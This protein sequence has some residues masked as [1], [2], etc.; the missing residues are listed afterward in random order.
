MKKNYFLLFFIILTFN[1]TYSQI[2]WDFNSATGLN[3]WSL[4]RLNVDSYTPQ[5]VI[6]LPNGQNNPRLGNTIAGIDADVYKFAIIKLKVASGGSDFIRINYGANFKAT[7]ITTGTSSIETYVINMTDPTWTGIINSIELAFRMNDGSAGGDGAVASGN[8]IELQEITFIENLYVGA[9]ELYVDLNAGNDNNDGSSTNPLLTIPHAID[10]A[11]SNNIANVYIKSGTYELTATQQISTDSPNPIVVSPEAN[12][13]VKFRTQSNIGFNFIND[14]NNIEF[15]GFEVDGKASNTE[16]WHYTLLS[17]YVWQPDLLTDEQRGG[18]IAFNVENASNIKITNNSIH[19][20]YQ[21]SVNIRNG[22]YVTVKGNVIYNIALTSLSGG[23]GIMRQQGAGSFPDADDPLKYRWDIDGNL[24]FNIHQR[25]YSWV[26]A[27]GYLNMTLDEGKPILIDETPNHDLGMKARIKDNIVAYFKIDG[28][29]IKPTNYLEVSN[30]SLY[31]TEPVGADGITDTTNG[32]SGS[33]TPFLEFKCFNNAVELDPLRQPYE[34]AESIGSTGS[35]YGNNHAAFGTIAPVGVATNLNTSL[36]EDAP[37]GYF[38]IKNGLP[39]NIGVNPVIIEE[40]ATRATQFNVEVA[41]NNWINNHLKNT[42]TLFDNIPGVDDGIANNETVFLDAGVYDLSDLEYSNGRKS[43][44]FSVNT[45][46]QTD[47]EVTNAVLNHGN[48]LDIYDG[49]YEIVTPEVYSEW[50]DDIKANHLRDTDN[51]GIGDTP[52]AVIRYGESVIRQNKILNDNSLH[53]IEIEA[54]YDYT[55]THAE[56]FDITLDGDI[57]IDFNYTPAGYEV[58]DLIIANNITTNNITD[59][60]DHITILGYTGSYTLEIVAGSPSVLRLTLTDL[61]Q[62]IIWKN[63]QWSNITG[64][65]PTDNALIDDDFNENVSIVCNDLTIKDNWIVTI[66]STNR[67]KVNGNLIN[68]G[69]IV[70]KSDAS[71]TGRFDSFSGSI[72]GPGKATVERFIPQG[73]RAFRF[74][75]PGVTTTNF[76]KNNWQ[77]DTHI[78]GSTTGAFGFDTT[79]TGNPSMFTYNNQVISGTGWTAIPSTNTTNLVAGLGYR[80]L[81]RGDRN[82]DIFSPSTPNM[83]AATTLKATGKITSGSITLNSSSIPAI[84]NTNNTT[85]ADFSLIGNPYISPINW[86]TITKSGLSNTY[87]AWD[88]NMGTSTQ[89]GRYVAY[90]G[91]T[92]DN[93]SSEVNEFIQTGQ[94][95]FVKNN[96]SGVAGSITFTENDKA[97]SVTNIYKST[98]TNISKI[99]VSLYDTQILNSGEIYPIDATTT[100]FNS[101]YSNFTDSFDA[102]KLESPGE[103]IAWFIDGTKL[104]INAF[105]EPTNTDVLPIKTLRLVANKTYSLK[106]K[107]EELNINLTAFL[108]DNYLNTSTI[109]PFDTDYFYDYLTNDDSNS[110]SENRFNIVFNST[111]DNKDFDLN[112]IRVYP[113]PSNS[114]FGFYL[115]NSTSDDITVTLFNSLGQSIKLNKEASFYKPE[116]ILNDGVYFIKIISGKKIKTI[117]WIVN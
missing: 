49:K 110:Y 5:S 58:F 101:S 40:L 28:I 45:T 109:I 74:L 67:L 95:F 36:F 41:D 3:G 103:N 116:G 37:N 65:T 81:I 75:T 2:I 112:S 80:V 70:F 4:T 8:A 106:T 7:P 96:T 79:L 102:V 20:F 93:P 24:L 111:L 68:S 61:P 19:D 88:P 99:D 92:N 11:A 48:G 62:P 98:I 100:I 14:A 117:K 34:L 51:N 46:W 15:I 60:F 39:P 25:I 63:Q 33:G 113:N 1:F 6:L 59:I 86:N 55:K 31:S 18:G 17:E 12:G 54:S 22:R 84:N 107:I 53:V 69:T 71:G 13:Y 9:T 76:I 16:E 82:A 66:G 73:K 72:T 114:N 87:Y 21:K 35:T 108:V 27:K 23:H 83:N 10:I 90:N 30:N 104:A 85:T 43:Y 91:V 89:R 78:T 52:Y 94:A 44:Y 97:S 56:G 47:K 105:S 115:L 26:P 42:Q 50:Y 57:L 29:R 64:P 38:Q 77:L 32:F